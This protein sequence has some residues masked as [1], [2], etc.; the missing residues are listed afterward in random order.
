[1][2]TFGALIGAEICEAR[3]ARHLTQ[4]IVA[5]KVFADENYVRRIGD[6]ETGKVDRPQAKVYR[7]ICDFLGVTSQRIRALKAEASDR[8]SV[9][10]DEIAA[11]RAEKG[12]LQQALSD[13]QSLSREQLETLAD[14][15]EMPEA[16]DS[17]D[18]ALLD[19]LSNKAEDYRALRAEIDS[20]DDR[21]RALSNLKGSALAAYDAGNLDEVDLLLDRVMEIAKEESARAAEIKAD[22]ALLRGRHDRALALLTDAADSFAVLDPLEP[23]RRRMTYG[24]TMYNHGLRY[25]GPGLRFAASLWS[26]C[27]EIATRAGDVVRAAGAKCNLGLALQNQGTRTGG[28]EGAALLAEAVTSYR[29]ALEVYTRD[30][31]PVHWATTQNNLAIALQEQGTRTGGSEGAA[32]L[33]EAVTTY[34]AA[35]EVY[36]REAHPVDGAM[37]QEN[38]ALAELA[39]A[40]HDSCTDPLP[41]LR[42]ALDHVTAALEVF[43]PEHMPYNFD[44]ATALKTRL[45]TRIAGA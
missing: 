1:M 7:P 12:S 37:T 10:D 28:A 20:I 9:T 30:A 26:T 16:G 14:R 2:P 11:L 19:F 13:L 8:K 18:V 5:Q 45:E 36:N 33:A 35:L 4:L 38:L 6:Y 29:D 17:S 25:G 42:A 3:E 40:D 22:A 43:D 24:K 44:K 32:L 34:R 27:A 21:V 31:H 23:A 41:L 39:R 15:F